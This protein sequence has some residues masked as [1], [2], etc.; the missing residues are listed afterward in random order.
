MLT[1][2]DGRRLTF[3]SSA[4]LRSC[5]NIEQVSAFGDPGLHDFH[6]TWID[7]LFARSV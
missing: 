2:A 7:E 3:E 1:L 4:N 5:M 6:R